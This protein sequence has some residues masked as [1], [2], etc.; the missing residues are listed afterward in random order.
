M[1]TQFP[2]AIDTFTDP[3]ASAPLNN[4]SHSSVHADLNAAILALEARVG[5]TSSA[6]ITSHDYRI[7]ALES[8]GG[9]AVSSVFGR[10]G[11]V[12]AQAGDYTIA[13]ITGLSASLAAL[14]PLDATLTAISNN[15]NFFFNSAANANYLRLGGG[16]TAGQ[17]RLLEGSGGGSN[18]AAIKSPATLAAD[19]T[20]TLPTALPGSTAFVKSSNAGVLSFD[21]STYLT[22]L[23][24]GI[25][26]SGASPNDALFVDGH[27]SLARSDD[28]TFDG[29]IFA[30]SNASVRG[31]LSLPARDTNGVLF[32]NG[33]VFSDPTFYYDYG[34]Q[35]FGIGNAS[36]HISSPEPGADTN[37]TGSGF[38]VRLGVGQDMIYTIDGFK[39]G[40]GSF[41]INIGGGGR[42]TGTSDN[43]GLPGQG[44]DASTIVLIGVGGESDVFQGC[45]V[46]L[47]GI[48]GR[49][50]LGAGGANIAGQSAAA[51]GSVQI[52]GAVDSDGVD[53]NFQSGTCDFWTT[54]TF[55][56]V[57]NFGP[58][59][60]SFFEIATLAVDNSISLINNVTGSNSIVPLYIDRSL[61]GAGELSGAIV[62]GGA[63]TSTQTFIQGYV[64]GGETDVFVYGSFP[65]IFGANGNY[66]NSAYRIYPASPTA[67]AGRIFN[68]FTINCS[69]NQDYFD[70]QLAF[71]SHGIRA[72]RN[73]A[74][75]GNPGSDW[76][77][78]GPGVAPGQ[79][80]LNGGNLVLSS[81][82][83]T[84]TGNSSI[85]IKAVAAGGSGTT[86]RLPS[87][88]AT[89]ASGSLTYK[90][91]YNEV[92]GTS[93]GQKHATAAN[94]KQAWW[95]AT[96]IVQPTT[97]VASATF[98]DSGATVVHTA[99]TFDGYT[100][101]QIVK[102][103]RNT[104][105]L[106]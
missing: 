99:S 32:M 12:T 43:S 77:I 16:T 30:T 67:A 9:G 98:A 70:L 95:N 40:N 3:S 39:A 74:G 34:A 83:A 35:V 13:Q 23:S 29:S 102:A 24:I 15:T 5:I 88:V 50:V 10:S 103:L 79:T 82:E 73:S 28:F 105:L 33:T 6:V 89:F 59:F 38:S 44:G 42:A 80:D 55:H 69:E 78:R 49:V 84:G 100:L 101:S 104:G 41:S 63:L 4:P 92:Y 14:Q 54:T 94:Q 62:F 37:G 19:Y 36:S 47:P 106:A 61:A 66:T 45:P 71:S 64:A 21:T 53:A 52:G 25:T 46:G 17:L 22:G 87:T 20:L 57:T 85:L 8:G 81:G 76:E 11:A 18:F 68:H 27:N 2:A 91:G 1:P 65:N 7:H 51:A 72:Q 90:D 31:D 60:A 26:V 58:T 97:S 56:G 86:D 75:S 93:T 48:G 96:P